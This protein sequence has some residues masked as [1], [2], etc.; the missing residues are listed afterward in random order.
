[1]NYNYISQLSHIRGKSKINCI[2]VISS[3]TLYLGTKQT[4][5]DQLI[6]YTVDSIEKNNYILLTLLH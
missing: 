3:L 5:G 4:E 2:K 1:M 6:P